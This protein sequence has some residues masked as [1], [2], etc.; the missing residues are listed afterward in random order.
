MTIQN[1]IKKAH[2]SWWAFL[3]SQI[4]KDSK[5]SSFLTSSEIISPRRH[6]LFEALKDVNKIDVVIAEEP[7]EYYSCYKA[8]GIAF[9]RDNNRL[10]KVL[11][12]AMYLSKSVDYINNSQILLLKKVFINGVEDYPDMKESFDR[13]YKSIIKFLQL[14]KNPVIIYFGGN[15]I[16]T[17][18][19]PLSLNKYVDTCNYLNDLPNSS[20]YAYFAKLDES[21]ETQKLRDILEAVNTILKKKGKLKIN[22]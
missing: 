3:F 4:N 20:K 9:Q 5:L 10:D 18:K 15:Y 21:F 8:R 2:H 6:I 16:P 14:R 22:W 13:L 19:K 11:L 17:D 12:K 1:I 7:Q